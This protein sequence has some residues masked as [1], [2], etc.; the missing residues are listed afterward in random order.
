MNAPLGVS[1]SLNC[2]PRFFFRK[3]LAL[4]KNN[5]KFFVFVFQVE[6]MEKMGQIQNFGKMKNDFVSLSV[7]FARLQPGFGL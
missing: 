2:F 7:E 6:E 5:S 1:A 4:T 3:I